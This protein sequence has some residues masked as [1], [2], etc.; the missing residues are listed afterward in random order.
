MTKEEKA[1]YNK[2]Y[3]ARNRERLLKQKLEWYYS[4]KVHVRNHR[5]KMDR[6]RWYGLEHDDYLKMLEKQNNVCA[7]CCKPESVVNP[8]GETKPLSVDHDHATGKVRGLLC[9]ACNQAIGLF[10]DDIKTL[11]S[12][13][14]Y[15]EEDGND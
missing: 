1:I 14:L 15:L 5:R 9:S 12:A 3:Q 7:I 10:K 13:I 4:N 11:Q 6:K 8:S 2:Q